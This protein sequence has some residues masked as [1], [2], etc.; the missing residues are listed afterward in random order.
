MIWG[1]V[2]ENKLNT[3]QVSM[4]KSLR[5]ILNVKFDEN[6]FSS[7]STNQMFKQLRLLKIK[8]IYN[9]FCI[10]FIHSFLYGTRSRIFQVHFL[11]LLP[12]HNYNTR[13]IKMNL[14]SIRIETERSLPIFNCVCLINSVPDEL[15]RPQSDASL[16]RKVK[17]YFLDKY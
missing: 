3:I 11:H 8:D 13:N 15:I 4:N 6:I 2:S 12:N 10:K 17:L 16:K 14:P 7:I 9:Y 1:G 5:I